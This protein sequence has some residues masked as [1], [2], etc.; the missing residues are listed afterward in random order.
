MKKLLALTLFLILLQ[1][2]LATVAAVFGGVNTA[3]SALQEYRE[4]KKNEIEVKE[5]RKA[6]DIREARENKN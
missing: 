1:G 3:Y 2:C 4:F 6:G 5:R